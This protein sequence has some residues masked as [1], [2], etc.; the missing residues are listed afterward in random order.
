MFIQLKFCASVVINYVTGKSNFMDAV[1]FVMGEKTSSLRVKRLSDLIH[2][3][4]IGQPV[5]RT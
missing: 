4:S 1:S 5:S 2:G 3:A